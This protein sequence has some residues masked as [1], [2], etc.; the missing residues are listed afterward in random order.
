MTALQE[1]VG[2]QPNSAL[3]RPPIWLIERPR[4]PFGTRRD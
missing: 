1:R 3:R 4:G 2:W